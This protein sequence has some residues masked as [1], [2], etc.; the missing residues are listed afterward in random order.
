MSFF[1]GCEAQEKSGQGKF[2]FNRLI[3]KKKF[4]SAKNWGEQLKFYMMLFL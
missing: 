1:I 3:I 2:V 4:L